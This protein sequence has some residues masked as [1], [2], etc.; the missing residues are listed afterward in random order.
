VPGDVLTLL[1]GRCR[2]VK[3]IHFAVLERV[4]FWLSQ[5]AEAFG[6]A[7]VRAIKVQT[8]DVCMEMPVPRDPLA[9]LEE[10]KRRIEGR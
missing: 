5:L 2:S 8:C 9:V 7:D 1:C 4:P 6:Q 3:R 10:F